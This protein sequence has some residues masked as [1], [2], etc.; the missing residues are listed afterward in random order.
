MVYRVFAQ[1]DDG[2]EDEVFKIYSP[3]CGPGPDRG[4][5]PTFYEVTAYKVLEACMELEAFGSVENPDRKD[6]LI[7]LSEYI[8]ENYVNPNKTLTSLDFK[9]IQLN[10]PEE[11]IGSDSSWYVE[12]PWLDAYSI[13]MK[14]ACFKRWSKRRSP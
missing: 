9:V 14:T 11:F 5:K 10:P 12:E 3:D 6:F 1:Y 7:R 13:K 2:T 4:F 8:A